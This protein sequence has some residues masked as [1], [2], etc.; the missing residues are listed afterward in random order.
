MEVQVEQ[1]RG[2]VSPSHTASL[3][4]LDTWPG[5]FMLSGLRGVCPALV[6]CFLKFRATFNLVGPWKEA[7]ASSLLALSE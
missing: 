4:L 1:G 2:V 6:L 5:L 7:S 3:Q